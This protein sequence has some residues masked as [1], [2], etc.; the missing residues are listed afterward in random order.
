M[1]D[2]AR[3]FPANVHNTGAKQHEHTTSKAAKENTKQA[4]TNICAFLESCLLRHILC[5][6]G[7]AVSLLGLTTLALLLLLPLLSFLLTL[8]ILP[9]PWSWSCGSWSC[10]GRGNGRSLWNG[11]TRTLP[12][13]SWLLHQVSDCMHIGGVHC[14]AASG[15][16]TA[17]TKIDKH[18]ENI[19]LF[20]CIKLQPEARTILCG[21]PNL[22][23][24]KNKL[25][26]FEQ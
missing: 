23:R 25:N 2:W 17:S 16:S 22:P 3:S 7:S 5:L 20:T 18:P 24:K 10:W 11:L 21:C 9:P 8:R 13:T 1:A 12:Q 26:Q 6:L 4:V 15:Q 19:K 14:D